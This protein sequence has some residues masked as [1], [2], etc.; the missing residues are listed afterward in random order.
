MESATIIFF[1]SFGAPS[2]PKPENASELNDVSAKLVTN[3][4]RNKSY[5]NPFS[6]LTF[7]SDLRIARGFCGGINLAASKQ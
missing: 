4:T 5:K 6:L 2:L 7:G 3:S 1:S